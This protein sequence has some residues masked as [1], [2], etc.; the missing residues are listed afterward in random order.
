MEIND[1]D[2][3]TIIWIDSSLYILDK[4]NYLN[5]YLHKNKLKPLFISRNEK[6][7]RL[8]K[9]RGIISMSIIQTAI[10]LLKSTRLKDIIYLKNGS[11]SIL[12][13]QKSW[14]Y[15]HANL[16]K[17]RRNYSFKHFYNYFIDLFL[18]NIFQV[19]II[20]LIKKGYLK[21]ILILNGLNTFG[22]LLTKICHK[23]NLPFM[24]WENGLKSKTLFIHPFGVNA[25]G[26]KSNSLLK[27]KPD[28]IKKLKT[29]INEFVNPKSKNILC[30]LQFDID[31]NILCASQFIDCEHFLK[32][33]VFPLS[34]NLKNHNF[35]IRPHPKQNKIKKELKEIIE[36][37]HNIFIDYKKNVDDTL[38]NSD[39]VICINSTVGFTAFSNGIPV[40]SF[41]R[42]FWNDSNFHYFLEINKINFEF[43]YNNST[44]NSSH[45]IIAEVDKRSLCFDEYLP[46]LL[47]FNQAS[48][49]QYNPKLFFPDKIKIYE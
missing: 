7:S 18:K 12:E 21:N 19:S 32:D 34:Q 29:F 38:D 36:N 27:I 14:D 48:F 24:F 3:D 37:S 47:K 1:I 2:F 45:N 42:S 22:Y 46:S 31:T 15:I 6:I 4:L 41:G 11:N 13:N 49:M 35:F 44:L 26:R 43:F 16:L 5:R 25:Y 9:K 17:K 23:Y 20:F 30:P 28:K 40:I 39:L 10:F 8:L 33:I